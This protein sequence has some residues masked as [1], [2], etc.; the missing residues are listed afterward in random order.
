VLH[1]DENPGG[2]GASTAFF[3]PVLVFVVAMEQ[4]GV[5]WTMRYVY[6]HPFESRLL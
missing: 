2:A 1:A 3:R 5:A 4:V 6:R